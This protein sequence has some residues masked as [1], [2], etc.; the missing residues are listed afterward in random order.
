MSEN[1]GT[2][3][4]SS[5]KRWDAFHLRCRLSYWARGII[6]SG[7]KVFHVAAVT[8]VSNTAARQLAEQKAFIGME[9]GCSSVGWPQSPSQ[10]IYNQSAM[11]YLFNIQ[12]K[13]YLLP[14]CWMSAGETSCPGWESETEQSAAKGLEKYN[15]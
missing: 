15:K 1:S 11:S 8:P 5:W 13:S 6:V 3:G 14:R 12:D 2:E 4:E 10:I 7:I 9:S